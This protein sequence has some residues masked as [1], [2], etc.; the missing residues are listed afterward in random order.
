MSLD[1]RRL[2]PFGHWTFFSCFMGLVVSLCV[3]SAPGQEPDPI[4]VGA[5]HMEY[6][7]NG[8]FLIAIGNV[9]LTQLGQKLQADYVQIETETQEALARG[10]VVLT[11][12]NGTIWKGEELRHNFKTGQGQMSS[13]HLQGG[14]YNVYSEGSESISPGLVRLRRTSVSPCDEEARNE[15]QIVAHSA[16]VRDRRYV[17]LRNSVA[18]LGPIPV[19]YTPYWRKDLESLGRL[20][21]VPGYS[22][23][24]GAFFLANYTAPLNDR[25]TVRSST[26]LNGY[27]ERGVGFGQDLRWNDSGKHRRGGFR[28]FY[29]DDTQLY[30]DTAEEEERSPI[31]TDSGRYRFR[32]QHSAAVSDRDSLW[33][34]TS[35]LSDPW[36]LKDFFREEYRNSSQPDNR[37][38]V[39][40]RGE[41]FVASLLLQPRLNDFFDYVTRMPEVR[42]DSSL[43]ELGD[44]GLF[45]ESQSTAS[46]LDQK[47]ATT[48]EGLD[49][50][51]S[52]LDTAHTLFYPMRSFGFLNTTPQIGYRATY[53]SATLG[54]EVVSTNVVSQVDTNGVTTLVEEEQRI[55][56]EEGAKLRSLYNLGFET[57]FKAFHVLEDGE[58]TWGKG[59]RH[60]AEPYMKYNFVPEPN[61]RPENIYYFDSVDEIDK[62]HSVTLGMRNKLQTHRRIPL[63]APPPDTN[64]GVLPM[65]SRSAGNVLNLVDADVSN[66]FRIEKEEEQSVLGPLGFDVRLRPVAWFRMNVDGQYDWDEAALTRLNARASFIA[67]NQS[68]LALEQ[69]YYLDRRNQ[70]GVIANLYPEARWSLR[71]YHRYDFESGLLAE[72]GY[73]IQRRLRCIALG[74]GVRIEP[75]YKAGESDDY[76]IW[77]HFELLSVHGSSFE[78]GE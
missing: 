70:L 36:V 33:M 40:H 63:K 10:H 34:D 9:T 23:S 44:S 3:P 49:Y 74:L 11:R 43:V 66:L 7:G 71:T 67:E 52:R 41:G 57:S 4:N 68:S 2:S 50:G 21:I 73:R 30:R 55:R 51:A 13:F 26:H 28:G 78:I 64:S 15:F 56:P 37:F 42:L 60:V 39:S 72:H 35:Y 22:S 12:A 8:K 61:L 20:D 45:H 46:Q 62:D 32:L 17:T 58:T 38:V 31:L 1:L 25:G 5:D 48:D 65:E 77:A 19:F 14:S 47:Y 59:L 18:W 29:I 54:D 24:L 16:E 6:A 69:S 53:Y 75:S 76:R 27:S